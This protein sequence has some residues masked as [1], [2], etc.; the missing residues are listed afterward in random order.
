METAFV[1]D[2]NF[3][4]ELPE[5]DAQHHELVDLFNELSS[6]LFSKRSDRE[7]VLA[8]TYARLLSYTEHHFQDEEALMLRYGVDPRHVDNHR[9][10]HQQ[11][12]EQV[13]MLWA[14][15]STMAD[16]ATTLVGFLTSWLGLHILGI[17]QSMARQIKAIQEGVAPE[18][19]YEQEGGAHDNGTQALLKMIGKLYTALSAQNAQL[20]LANQ[21]LEARVARRTRELEKANERLKE[22][23]N[24][25]PLLGVANRA[26]LNER[27][28]QLYAIAR[29]NTRPIGMVL[30]DVDYFKRY[31][32][33][34]GH[35]QGDTCLRAVANAI[36]SCLHRQTDFVARYG[37]EEF[38]VVLPDSDLNGCLAVAQRIVYAV[39]AL[40]LPH[41]ASQVA[42]V[43]TVSAGAGSHVPHSADFNQLIQ[44][45]DDALYRAKE[46][47]RNR[48]AIP[49]DQ[50]LKV[51]RPLSM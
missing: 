6:G 25:D 48:A 35:L 2:Q 43:V 8:D 41:E 24:T 12:I 44:E 30:V 23:S 16:P 42:S 51:S 9:M 22:L 17:D 11:F 37:G 49:S 50:E 36:K 33:R 14:Q 4:T 40:Q 31:N 39:N 10:M 19:A 20:A 18:Q 26:H 45:A 38:A 15:R 34:Y 46:G 7:A 21:T 1:W 27:L 28:A 29:R 47:G 32:D 13:I 5:V 3:V